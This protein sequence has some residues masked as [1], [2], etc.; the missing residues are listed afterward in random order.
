M[1]FWLVACS[2]VMLLCA[3]NASAQ[4]NELRSPFERFTDWRVLVTASASTPPNSEWSENSHASLALTEKQLTLNQSVA[5]EYGD[6]R[7]GVNMYS[8]P[9]AIF[10][11][12]F[13]NPK[14]DLMGW[15]VGGDSSRWTLSVRAENL[16]AS[17]TGNEFAGKGQSDKSNFPDRNSFSFLVSWWVGSEPDSAEEFALMQEALYYEGALRE[18]VYARSLGNEVR[19]SKR[20]GLSFALGFGTGKYA[21]S[22]PLSKHLNLLSY[23]DPLKAEGFS[24][25]NPLIVARYRLRNLIAQFDI[26]GED[27]NLHFMLRN[28]RRLDI[29]TGV[30]HLEHLFPRYSR[31]PHRPEAY[32]TFR[33]AISTTGED[34]LQASFHE[35]G[36]AIVSPGNDSDGDGLLDGDEILT[37][38]TNP[39]KK[40]TDS[41]GLTDGDEVLVRK[42]N[43]KI[44]D[45]DGD[46]LID[47]DEINK[48]KTSPRAADTD[49]DGLTDG[50]E[51]ATYL[52][53]PLNMDTDGD[54]LS[55]G[56]EV[57]NG[58]KPVDR[59]SDGDGLSD[60]DEVNQYRTSPKL[61]DTDG[62][63]LTD[64]EEVFE[65]KTDPLLKDTDGD[66]VIDSKDDCP[67]TAGVK[68]SN[69]CPPQLA[70]GAQLDIVGIEFETG[71][72][73]ILDIS[74]SSLER[75]EQILRQYPAMR[76]SIEGHTDNQGDADLNRRLALDRSNA[77]RDWIT[78]KGIDSRRIETKGFGEDSPITTNETEEGRAR[79]RRIEFFV[80]DN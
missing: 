12:I 23:Y 64:Y 54:G 25:I 6:F 47:G 79:N 21:G 4:F 33:Y 11:F 15:D 41:D 72:A 9:N 50:E 61:P 27:I 76:I 70:A 8:F 30:L 32:L 66:G 31:G 37:Y 77:V 2:L 65:E 17:K 24:G 42:T 14:F 74:L 44:T 60:G 22:G 35:V 13:W 3:S 45:T 55:D 29:E 39:E 80:I 57:R 7:V 10:P 51:I 19:Y 69:G 52:T 73:T 20:D 56:D 36:D 26:A 28:L 18:D 67:L 59:D 63:D 53:K 40:D 5:M 1:S 16:F 71:L 75:V 49:G 78:A 68:E 48:W 46:G 62:D 58:T 34:E 38:Q 43:P